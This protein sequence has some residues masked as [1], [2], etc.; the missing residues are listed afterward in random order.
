MKTKMPSEEGTGIWEQYIFSKLGMT[1]VYN[2]EMF[3]LYLD[4]NEKYV[5]MFL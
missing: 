5:D 2:L 1:F 4:K 3:F